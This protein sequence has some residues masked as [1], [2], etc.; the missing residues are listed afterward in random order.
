[1]SGA[2]VTAVWSGTQCISHAFAIPDEG[3]V[4]GRDL[5]PATTD[6]RISREHARVARAG[7]RLVVTDA[8]S[9]NGTYVNGRALVTDAVEVLPGALIRT[10]RTLW[11]IVSGAAG[12]D[13]AGKIQEIFDT[14]RAAA[15]DVA[16]HPS[17]FE[18][19]LLS[20]P[21]HRPLLGIVTNAAIQCAREGRDLRGGDLEVAPNV[22]TWAVF[23]GI[24][25]AVGAGRRI[26]EKLSGSTTRM[27]VGGNA[28]VEARSGTRRAAVTCPPSTAFLVELFDADILVASGHTLEDGE[29]LAAATAW[30]GGTPLGELVRAR[31]FLRAGA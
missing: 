18:E 8:G 6:D 1:M 26:A 2:E 10:G 15:K 24:S 13:V 31:A 23:P 25:S 3:L 28:L 9:R 22:G 29:A 4:L 5:L 27:I 19:C 30:L 17:L 14:V 7:D 12:R 21:T 20:P 16:I 11:A